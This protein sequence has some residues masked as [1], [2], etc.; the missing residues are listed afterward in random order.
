MNVLLK[1]KSF[2]SPYK[3]FHGILI[4][5]LVIFYSN[6]S[7]AIVPFI[8]EPNYKKIEETGLLF[9][10][11]AAHF[12]QRGQAIEASKL[13]ALAVSLKSDDEILWVILADAQLKNN[14]IDFLYCLY[15]IIS[16][17]NKKHNFD[18]FKKK[19]IADKHVEKLRNVY[20]NKI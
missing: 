14:Q 15:F 11:Q 10:K 12:L 9:G 18:Y 7:K 19:R 5:Y 1:N 20:F 3:W 2:K 6:P 17:L 16:L 13:A 4:I 8:F